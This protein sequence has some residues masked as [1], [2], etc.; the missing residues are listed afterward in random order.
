MP[1]SAGGYSSNTTPGDHSSGVGRSASFP[2]KYKGK[3]GTDG[4]L[5]RVRSPSSTSDDL[6]TLRAKVRRLEN[7]LRDLRGPRVPMS[8]AERRY[9]RMAV[10]FDEW[11]SIPRASIRDVLRELIRQS[12]YTLNGMRSGVVETTGELVA[13]ILGY[14]KSTV[15]RAFDWLQERGLL[16]VIE[17]GSYDPRARKSKMGKWQLDE[18]VHVRY[19]REKSAS[20]TQVRHPDSFSL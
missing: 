15:Y 5:E 19:T 12:G 2:R 17:K 1:C 20:R 8:E 18:Q 9:A 13:T 7:E 3:I 10:D 16:H 4:V 11:A 6:T 14:H